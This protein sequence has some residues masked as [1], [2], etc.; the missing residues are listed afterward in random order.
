MNTPSK[1]N[2]LTGGEHYTR[3]LARAR[4]LMALDKL[5]HQLVPAPLNEHCSPVTISDT[6]LILAAD[7]PAWAARLRF[8]APGLAK[9][10]AASCPADIRSV[11]VRVKPADSPSPKH[12]PKTGPTVTPAGAAALKQAAHSI[13]DPALKSGLL[14][15]ASRL[16]G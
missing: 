14:R 16:D 4:E 9:Q 1:V 7:S 2:K 15:L 3:L 11:S 12:K 10:L 13:S 6:T 8:L 5:L